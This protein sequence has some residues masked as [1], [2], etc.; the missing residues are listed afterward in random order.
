MIA[1]RLT[2]NGSGQR[3]ALADEAFAEMKMPGAGPGISMKRMMMGRAAAQPLVGMMNWAPAR[4]PVGQR[5]V[6][7]FILV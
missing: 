2:D 7:V 5:A 6:V 1:D 4:M 3:L